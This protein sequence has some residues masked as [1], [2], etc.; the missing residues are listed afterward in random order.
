LEREAGVIT[1]LV[2][3]DHPSVRLGVT[4]MLRDAGMDVLDTTA[5]AADAL[6]SLARS[7]PQV[8]IVDLRLTDRDG[9]E[10]CRLIRQRW[11]AVACLVYSAGDDVDLIFDA[12]NAG[13]SGMVYKGSPTSELVDAVGVVAA[14]GEVFPDDLPDRLI[15][16][17]R[18]R[19]RME[20]PE[21]LSSREEKVLALL[22]EGRSNREIATQLKLAEK[23]VRN[24]V[25][26]VLRKLGLHDRTQAALYAQRRHT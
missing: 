26:S 17:I 7:Q 4:D 12:I 1:L 10:L 9:A 16:A 6:A 24:H 22:G 18:S 5:T 20:R 21:L 8:A 15:E 23:T 25:S 11:P 14:G 13:V 3:D 2:V 19:T